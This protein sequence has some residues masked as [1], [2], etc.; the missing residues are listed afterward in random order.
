MLKN[1]LPTA[2]A[3]DEYSLAFQFTRKEILPLASIQLTLWLN[4]EFRLWGR[5]LRCFDSC[6][7]WS[8]SLKRRSLLFDF[9]FQEFYIINCLLFVILGLS[10]F[11]CWLINLD[12]L[13]E[14]ISL[15]AS[16]NQLSA[17]DISFR[18]NK[19]VLFLQFLLFV[20][21]LFDNSFKLIF[22]NEEIFDFL[23]FLS[24]ILLEFFDFSLFT[25]DL[26]VFVTVFS[27][28]L[29]QLVLF[30]IYLLL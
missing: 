30:C 4:Y 20:F 26:L 19:F 3:N 5:R 25:F 9:E 24:Y 16:S 23:L 17:Q 7:L 27:V 6:M 2:C 18:N 22:L 10:F 28:L 14:K 12:F 1:Q 11:Q 29:Y 15:C 21:N 13:I 8:H